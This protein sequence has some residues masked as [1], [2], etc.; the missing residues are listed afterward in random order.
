MLVQLSYVVTY[1]A[2]HG[3]LYGLVYTFESLAIVWR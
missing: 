3:I 2:M 1:P